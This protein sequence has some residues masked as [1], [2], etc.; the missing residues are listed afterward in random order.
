LNRPCRRHSIERAIELAV[1]YG[2]A[3]SRELD[4]AGAFF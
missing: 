4:S 2:T 3:R 1:V